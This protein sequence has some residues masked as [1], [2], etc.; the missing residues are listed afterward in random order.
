MAKLPLTVTG[1]ENLGGELYG[2]TVA[3]ADGSTANYII[4]VT[5]ATVE[6]VTI[7]AVAMGALSDPTVVVHTQPHRKHR[8]YTPRASY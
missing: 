2:V 8:R 7:S 1:V 4:P 3:Y 6:G 5:L